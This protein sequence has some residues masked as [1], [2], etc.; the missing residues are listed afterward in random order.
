MRRNLLAVFLGLLFLQFTAATARPQSIQIP[1]GWSS[2]QD[3]ANITYTPG[4]LPAGKKFAMTVFPAESL[5]GQ[6]LTVWFTQHVQ[7]DLRQRN[8]PALQTAPQ[9]GANGL[10]SETLSF[11]DKTGQNWTFI[12]AAAQNSGGPAE[13]CA[14]I[15]NLPQSSLATYLTP[16]GKLFGESVALARSGGNPSAATGAAQPIP[17]EPAQAQVNSGAPSVVPLLAESK[18]NTLAFKQK[19]AGRNVTLTGAING[20]YGNAQWDRHGLILRGKFQEDGSVYCDL[21]P[22]QADVTQQ[23]AKDQLVTVAA[24]F[25]TKRVYWELEDRMQYSHNRDVQL[26]SCR[27]VDFHPATPGDMT[28]PEAKPLGPSSSPLSGLY[29][30]TQIQAEIGFTSSTI[31]SF[32]FFSPD[33]HVYAGFPRN[34]TLDQFDFAAAAKSGPKLVGYY[35]VTGD[36]IDFVWAAGRKPENSKFARSGE[37]LTFS[38]WGWTRL[39]TNSKNFRPNWLAGTYRFQMGGSSAVASKFYTFKADGTFAAAVSS[40]VL[41][42]A[43][44]PQANQS[45]SSNAGGTYT[46]SGTTVTM[47]FAD[48]RTEQHTALPFADSVLVDGTLFFK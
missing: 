17:A 1:E 32:Y 18:D 31:W 43:A 9:Q 19:Y 38:G 2:S 21:A 27:V 25:D 7:A 44:V 12:Y 33:G 10:V 20:T 23:V 28:Y 24:R 3:G 42:R 48:G 11:R 22:N 47:K 37:G 41:A 26:E 4:N 29:Y 35:R 14:M 8:V 30:H 34:G 46:L 40:A 5:Q 36:R 6:D 16:A 45:Q 13:F 15:S 39:D